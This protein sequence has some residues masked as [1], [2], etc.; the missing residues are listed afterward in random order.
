MMDFLKIFLTTQNLYT[1]LTKATISSIYDIVNEIQQKI[2]A[3]QWIRDRVQIKANLAFWLVN[4]Y[5]IS[6][7]IG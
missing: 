1:Q 5:I 3:N 4:L 2:Y 7:M 6:N